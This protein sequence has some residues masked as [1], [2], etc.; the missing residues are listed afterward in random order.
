MTR[1][2]AAG[3]PPP[4]HAHQTN[5]R[6]LGIPAAALHVCFLKSLLCKPS[7]DEVVGTGIAIPHTLEQMRV[8]IAGGGTGGHVIPALAVAR[9]LKSRYEAEVLFV[10]TARGM[11]NRLVPQAG[12][13]LELVKVGALKNVS[14]ATRVKTVFDLPRAIFH[15]R[16]II[17]KFRPDVVIG[18]GGYASGPA[19]AAAILGRVPTLAFEPNLIPGFANKMVGRRVTAAAVHFEQT[20]KYF[21]NAHVVGVPVRPE[22]F[23]VVAQPQNHPPTLLVFG[24]SQG[25]HAINQALPAAIPEVQRRLPALRVIHQTGER[26]YNDVREAYSRAGIAAEVSAFIDD[27]PQAFARADLLVCRSGASTVAEITAAGKPAIFVPFPRAADDHQRHNA[28]AIADAGAAVL[29]P[30]SEL[31]PQRLAQKVTELLSDP[32][33]LQ[34]MGAKARKLGHRDAAGKMAEMAVAL[35]QKRTTEARRHG[36]TENV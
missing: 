21:R 5:P 35:T 17:R 36:G 2:F 18:V 25:A 24:G 14:L 32:G 30:E 19:M 9:E 27:M 4:H 28:E 10:G 15:S 8:L 22:F 7:K 6:V 20:G 33:K 34:A 1:P 31:T 29:I 13:A 16:R 23:N 3:A 26:D 12:F 11:E